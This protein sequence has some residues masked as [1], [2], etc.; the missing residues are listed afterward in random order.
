MEPIVDEL[1]AIADRLRSLRTKHCE[2]KSSANPSYHALS[3]AIAQLNRAIR[4]FE[5]DDPHAKE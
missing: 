2:P 3:T 5:D 4:A 1:G